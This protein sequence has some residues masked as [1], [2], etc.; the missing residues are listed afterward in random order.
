[1]AFGTATANKPSKF[2]LSSFIG[3][4]DIN[5]GE[6]KELNIDSLLPY[7]G[8]RQ[9]FSMYDNNKLNELAESIRING[10]LQP[11]LVRPT[12]GGKYEILAGHNRTEG[13]RRAELSTVKA[14]ILENLTDEQAAL[15]VT[16]TNLCQR[17]K[18]D[19]SERA[20]AYVIQREA[21]KK[22]KVSAPI[23]TLA[24][25]YGECHK[26]VQRYLKLNDLA[27]EV[28]KAVDAGQ[29]MVNAGAVLAGLSHDKQQGVLDFLKANPTKKISEAQATKI[30]KNDG[31]TDCLTTKP[32]EEFVTVKIPPQ[33]LEE[34]L[35]IPLIRIPDF[36]TFCL[37]SAELQ[38][39]FLEI[40]NSS[41]EE[42]KE[43]EEY[44]DEI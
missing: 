5:A 17:E 40:Y 15:V 1:M 36:V 11:I 44:E 23:D 18:I 10:L 12:E 32:R 29:I 28:L 31:G 35:Q 30:V 34:T 16:D 42:I 20:K 6:I 25:Q 7:K 27:P 37:Q 8:G 43:S 21:L 19:P 22:M 2:S 14:I 13:C 3:D 26:T 38:E 41:M 24:E 33:M 39:K 4:I 9:P